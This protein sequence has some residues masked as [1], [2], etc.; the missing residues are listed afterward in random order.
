MINIWFGSSWAQI[1]RITFLI[2]FLSLCLPSL[3]RPQLKLQLFFLL[4]TLVNSIFWVLLFTLVN[5]RV[6]VLT[7]YLC[8]LLQ[9]QLINF[10]VF[11]PT[12]YNTCFCR[13]RF[14][15][16][17]YDKINYFFPTVKWLSGF[18]KLSL[19]SKLSD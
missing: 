8:L 1:R 16:Y 13:Q 18:S 4:F 3:T 14:D 6:S 19:L 5:S 11:V 17:F 7:D 2:F 12:N 10:V 9:T 15:E